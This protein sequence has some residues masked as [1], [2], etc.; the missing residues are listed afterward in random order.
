NEGCGL[1]ATEPAGTRAMRFYPGTNV[2]ASPTRYTM[3]PE[4]VLT[5]LRDMEVN[6][7]RLGAIVHSHPTTEPAPSRTDLR[8]AYYPDALLVIVGFAAP[9]PLVR[10]WRIRGI[11]GETAAVEAVVRFGAD[12]P[13][14]DAEREAPGVPRP[15]ATSA[16]E[17][18]RS[19]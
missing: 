7:W 3:A 2:A 17:R 11:D 12:A 5:A 10:G 9:T 8:E 4:E 16:A 15:D 1:L 14:A 13:R 6:G 19:R 18:G